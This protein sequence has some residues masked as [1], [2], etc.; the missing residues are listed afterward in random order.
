MKKF[1]LFLMLVTSILTA[2]EK[3]QTVTVVE[4]SEVR[5][6]GLEGKVSI[7]KDN[8]TGCKYIRESYGSGYSQAIGLT[9]LLK[10]DGTPDCD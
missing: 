4:N 9:T 3:Q 6:A 10:S 8:E 2:C 7:V 1:L 5:F